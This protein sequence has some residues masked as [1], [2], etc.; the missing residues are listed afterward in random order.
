MPFSK[1]L[2]ISDRLLSSEIKQ[3]IKRNNDKTAREILLSDPIFKN[4]NQEGGK[5]KKKKSKRRNNKRNVNMSQEEVDEIL[6]IKLDDEP[7]EKTE[8]N[9][10]EKIEE[11][12]EEIGRAHV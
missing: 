6:G 12:S 1:S 5:P 2:S 3:F 10:E 8:E 11:I 9:R 4:S 7:E